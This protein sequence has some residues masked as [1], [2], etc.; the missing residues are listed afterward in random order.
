MKKKIILSSVYILFCLF[1]FNGRQG[2]K[3]KENERMDRE[4]AMGEKVQRQQQAP[5][6]ARFTEPDHTRK[7]SSSSQKTRYE[8]IL[9]RFFFF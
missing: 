7:K 1:M 6:T 5:L 4:K 3:R 2:K 9:Y 8:D